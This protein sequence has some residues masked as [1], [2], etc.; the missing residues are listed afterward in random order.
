MTPIVV[1]FVYLAFFFS[2]IALGFQKDGL[3]RSPEKKNDDFQVTGNNGSNESDK[4]V[5]SYLW[6]SKVDSESPKTELDNLLKEQK[7]FLDSLK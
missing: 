5:E 2:A 4:V 6:Q 3:F 7:K 1:F